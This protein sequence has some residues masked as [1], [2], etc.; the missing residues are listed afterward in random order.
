MPKAEFRTKSGGAR[1]S[2]IATASGFN[3]AH[4]VKMLS[5]IKSAMADPAQKPPEKM[6]C[7]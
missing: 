5:L 3:S 4:K 2:A 7:I 6:S 1:A